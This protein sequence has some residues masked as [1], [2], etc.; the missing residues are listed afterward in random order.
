MFTFNI[1]V[2]KFCIE[3][4]LIQVASSICLD[5]LT[6]ARYPPI[7]FVRF[8]SPLLAILTVH[9]GE[10]RACLFCHWNNDNVIASGQFATAP[11]HVGDDWT[12]IC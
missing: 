3:T 10:S 7:S 2:V 12:R 1:C 6:Y 9:C 5:A 8:F 11:C 4:R